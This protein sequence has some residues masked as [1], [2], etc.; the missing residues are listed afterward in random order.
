M[1]LRPPPPQALKDEKVKEGA[2]KLVM[3]VSERA[4]RKTRIRAPTKLHD[5]TRPPLL[6][7]VQ[8]CADPEVFAAASELVAQLGL[9][10]EVR[11]A[12]SLVMVHSSHTVLNDAGI[13]EHSKEFASDVIGDDS[14]QRTS[15]DALWKTI[16]YSV[17]PG[18]ISVL[19][20]VGAGCMLLSAF[21]LN[22]GGFVNQTGD[23][24]LAGLSINWDAL[25][26]LRGSGLLDNHTVVKFAGRFIHK[27]G[28]GLMGVG[29]G[30]MGL[31]WKPKET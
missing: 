20:G 11:A 21:A 22:R 14:V 3:K 2:V 10:E 5:Y 23:G 25:S 6:R 30:L 13:L 31:V 1:P 4:L 26:S 9:E 16:T 27:I 28:N 29:N 24:G 7:S 8:L 12:T 18:F 15:G 17:R 19:G